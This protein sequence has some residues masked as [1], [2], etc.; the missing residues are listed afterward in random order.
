MGARR[1]GAEV[2]TRVVS[3]FHFRDGRQMERWFYPE[4]RQVWD[5]IYTL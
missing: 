2:E 3:E 4:D 5:R 1:E